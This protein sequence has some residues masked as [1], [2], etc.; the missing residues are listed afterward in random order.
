MGLEKTAILHGLQ[1][2]VL[3]LSKGGMRRISSRSPQEEN[4]KGPGL[5]IFTGISLFQTEW[6]WNHQQDPEIGILRRFSS[7]ADLV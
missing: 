1:R 4:G 5:E 6:N 3:K 2:R 7:E